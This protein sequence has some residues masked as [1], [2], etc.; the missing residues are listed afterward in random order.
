MWF[1]EDASPVHEAYSVKQDNR[2]PLWSVA[3][4]ADVI[5]TFEWPERDAGPPGAKVLPPEVRQY[6]QGSEPS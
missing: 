4:R 5:M 6:L 2:P 3:E 1:D